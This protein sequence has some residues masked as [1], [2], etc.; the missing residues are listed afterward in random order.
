ME[1]DFEEFISIRCGRA[2]DECKKYI[3]SEENEELS[4]DE[5]QTIAEKL[6]YKK[7][8]KD[9]LAILKCSHIL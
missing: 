1:K 4:P 6:C 2:L 3:E 7:G 8:F 5:L 9:A